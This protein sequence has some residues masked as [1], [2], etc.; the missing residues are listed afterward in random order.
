VVRALELASVGR[1]LAPERDRLWSDD[2]R[3][4]A[5]IV[6]LEWRRD[7]L[8]ERIRAR[9]RAMLQ[10]GAVDEVRGLI[11]EGVQ[12]SRTAARILGLAEL[13]ALC[14]GRMSMTAC[15]D[16]IVLRTRQYARRQ[17]TW[18]RKIPGAVVLPGAA[19]AERNA[20]DALALLDV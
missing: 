9:T 12:L 6:V 13:V 4:P 19:G 1:S 5:I 17:E 11:I 8:L 14:E 15:E 2:L 3:V 16:E 20:D 7:V 18:A 10:G